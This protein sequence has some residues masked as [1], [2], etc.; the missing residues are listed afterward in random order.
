VAEIWPLAS[1]CGRQRRRVML[2]KLRVAV[3]EALWGECVSLHPAECSR[4]R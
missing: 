2:S 3:E 4:A 1:E